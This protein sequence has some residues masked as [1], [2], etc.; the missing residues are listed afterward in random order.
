MNA[1]Q[2]PADAERPAFSEVDFLA[3]LDE[4]RTSVL[5]SEDHGQ[6][7]AFCVEFGIAGSGRTK[8]E[9]VQNAVDLMMGY[10][11]LSYYEGRSYRDAKKRPPVNVRLRSWYLVVRTKLLRGIK[12]PLSRLGG[13]VSV[14]TTNRD[15]RHLAH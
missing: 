12:P 4:E 10:L 5:I 2:T 3:W 13:L 7:Y 9:A 11:V 8:D 14:P 15:A 6:V 1:R